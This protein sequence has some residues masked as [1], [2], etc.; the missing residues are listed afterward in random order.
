MF[1]PSVW[2]RGVLVRGLAAVLAAAALTACGG[3]DDNPVTLLGL[4]LAQVG[5]RAVQVSWSDDPYVASF[6]VVRDGYLLARVG[7]LAVVDNSVNVNQTYC[8]QVR[9]YDGY[10]ALIAS[11]DV[12]CI[13]VRP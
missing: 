1:Q 8:Y 2:R 10:D 3:G 5:P 11:T 13:T 6:D 7:T 4:S 9:G 12:G